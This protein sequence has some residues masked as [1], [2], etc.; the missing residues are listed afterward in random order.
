LKFRALV[1]ALLAV[2]L[3]A[4]AIAQEVRVRLYSA[5]QLQSL[6]IVATAGELLWKNCANCAQQS[7]RDLVIQN[8][9]LSPNSAADN[10]AAAEEKVVDKEFFVSGAY[11]LEPQSGAAFGAHYPLYVAERR[12][13]LVVIATLPLEDY[14]AYV[15]MAESGDFRTREALKA[16]AV[17]VR[18]YAEK[19]RNQHG[20]EGFDFCD[21]THC[22]AFYE[23]EVSERISSIVESTKGEVLS[24]NGKLASTYY[25]QDCGGTVA[26]SE[27]WSHVS[28]PYLVL[29]QDPYCMTSGGFKWQATLTYDQIDKALRASGLQAPENWQ[30]IAVKER[31][32]SGR[33]S[34]V[35]FSGGNPAAYPLSASTLRYAVDRAYGWNNIRSNWFDIRAADGKFVFSGRGSGHGVGLC[36]AGVEEMARE[37]K[38]YREILTFYYPGTQLMPSLAPSPASSQSSTGKEDWE[39]RSDEHFDLISKSPDSDSQILPVAERLLREDEFNIGW[40]ISS[41]VKL[42][43]FASL[44]SYRDTTGQPGWVA[45]STRGQTIR[46]QPLAELR[47][48]SILESTLRH[49]LYH[50]LVEAHAAPKTPVWFREGLV[51]YFSNPNAADHPAPSMNADEI[52]RILSHGDSRENTQ[53]A[54]ESAQTITA[55]LIQQHG[56]EA[57]L[58]WLS[59]GL[60]AGVARDASEPAGAPTHN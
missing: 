57:V 58:K 30:E 56:K 54:Y 41:R 52:E 28:E 1:P 5:R 21:T 25:H 22:Q 42:Q 18:T 40:R 38:S 31:S 47:K 27:A 20:A 7:G 55:D 60:P 35:N 14:V 16:M 37:G 6:N 53:K 34:L 17:A 44:D 59:D 26:A 13:G 12:S 36:Q 24:Y 33:A 32:E 8:P 39:K 11:R 51:L 19:F 50:L 48:R 43:V 2:T 15:L 4:T 10:T 49:E 46:L 9:G 3:P 23:G 45:A 29:H